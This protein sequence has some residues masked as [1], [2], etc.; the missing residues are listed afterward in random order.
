[1]AVIY[2]KHC[3]QI[4]IIQSVDAYA[5]ESQMLVLP[6]NT[7]TVTTRGGTTAAVATN[8][9]IKIVDEDLNHYTVKEW[10]ERSVATGFDISL[11]SKPIGFSVECNGVRVVF[12]WPYNGQIWNCIGTASTNNNLPHSV[13]D[14]N[15]VTGAG[16]G[17]DYH[18]VY[19]DNLGTGAPGSHNAAE[20]SVTD[21]GD[22]LTLYCGN[23]KRSWS[24]AKGCGHVD[25][26][27]AVNF[28]DRCDAMIAQNEWLRDRFAVCSG[29]VASGSEG[30]I[31]DVEILNESGVQAGVG[32]DM[33]FWIGGVNSGLKAK[34]NVNNRHGTGNAYYLSPEIADVIYEKQKGNGVN[35]NDT[36][37]NSA[38]KPMLVRGAKGAEA[39]AV[40][41]FWYIV[42]PYVSRPDGAQEGIDYNVIDSP[43][44]YYCRSFGG[45]FRVVGD[46]ELLA[47]CAN[48]SMVEGLF[49]YLRAYENW[50]NV[51]VPAY[52]NGSVW[53][54]LKR[55]AGSAWQISLGNGANGSPYTSTP[56]AV[57]PV[58]SF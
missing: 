42:T 29:I 3:L 50:A 15:A 46:R 58:S 40:N 33:F 30:S 24:M 31:T 53:T 44:F 38:D 12:R 23:T 49:T 57:Y 21:N 51:V 32:E 1:M 14:H 4:P 43:L 25:L 52:I 27:E 26:F 6:V 18:A 35:M 45:G 9:H 28:G 10:N 36:G 34:Y 2:F 13:A 48:R 56:L 55:N 39:I 8:D 54:C 47:A 22:N 20:W 17:S 41:G 7:T 5:L 37:V 16:S 11:V 19:D